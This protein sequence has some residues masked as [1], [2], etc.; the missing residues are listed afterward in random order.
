MKMQRFDYYVDRKVT[1]WQRSHLT[2]EAV[3]KEEA[4]M[5]VKEIVEDDNVYDEPHFVE[6]ETL[7]ETF[8][9]MSVEENDGQSTEEL[10]DSDNTLILDN[11]K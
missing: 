6:N 11:T 8:E 9:Q 5:K 10:F 7:F 4:D 3:S 1:G 2:I